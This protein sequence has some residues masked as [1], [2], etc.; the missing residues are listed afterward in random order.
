[1]NKIVVLFLILCMSVTFI[2][3]SNKSEDINIVIISKGYQ[4]EFWKSV[5]LGSKDAANELGVKVTF[6]GPEKETEIASQVKMVLDAIDNKASV[7]I[8]AAL[9]AD[10]LSPVVEKAKNS[11]IKI[12]TFDS[13]VRDEL[14]LS[15]AA[16]DN[17]AASNIAGEEMAKA[18]G[19]K[20]K[21]AIVSHIAGSQSAIDREKGFKDAIS[22]YPDIQIINTY[23]GD[24]DRKKS[25]AITADILKA[26]PDIV[27]IYGT[28]EGAA[29]GV[30]DA[31]KDVNMMGR[32]NIIGFDSS[33]DE[34]NYIN[35]GTINGTVVQ[36]P[37]K[38]GYTSVK[39]A[40]EVLKGNEIEKNID[41]GAT[42]IGKNN[43]NSQEAEKLIYPL[44]KN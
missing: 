28:C 7:I 32:I 43:I 15:F 31:V 18:I 23:Y 41:T 17:V 44:G 22:K 33:K 42:Y 35:D 25:K 39:N 29:V 13:N 37:Y 3:C 5:E 21:V 20:G 14:S 10:L 8:L 6:E 11:G 2:S 12:L 30:G 24:G 36:N 1:M 27:G 19:K 16:T 34:I 38:I 9:D 4:Q 40:V 26:N